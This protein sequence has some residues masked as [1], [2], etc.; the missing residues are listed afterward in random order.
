[1]DIT[2][3]T[4]N[5]YWGVAAAGEQRRVAQ[6][7]LEAR[8]GLLEQT[9]AQYEVGV[10]SR[11]EVTEAE[12]GVAEGELG[13]IVAEN[14]Y[15]AAQDRLIDL[16]LGPNLTPDS[17]LEIRPTDS[18]EEI[19]TYAVDPEQANRKAL[20]HRPELEQARRAVQQQE[21]ELKFRKNQRLPQVDLQFN[22]GY[23]GLAGRTN[24]EET[25]FGCTARRPPTDPVCIADPTAPDCLP[26]PRCP[27]DRV[28]SVRRSYWS[29]DDDFFSADGAKQWSGGA[30]VTIPIGNVSGR[31]GVSRARLELRRAHT[32]LKR[33]ELD[34]V[35]EVREAIRNLDSSLE[36]I[37]AAERRRVAAAEQLRAE[38]IRLE[39]GEST[40]FDVL[41]REEQL[42]DAESQK[43]NALQLYKDSVT[44]LDRAQGTIL[45]NNNI[46]VEEAA[47]LR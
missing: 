7:S 14:A 40:P 43:I 2:Q 12:A 24:P 11:V 36:G 23:Q 45:R 3:F 18:P 44:A 35:L 9:E 4:A 22:Y 20:T 15:R 1:M 6:K 28:T 33:V 8:R 42:V 32:Q 17:Q 29:T 5:A 38:N 47:V 10:V 34:I 21:I 37:E 26:P 25:F 13:V 27:R 30:V 46:V 39:H 41:Q 16:V 31:A 19:V